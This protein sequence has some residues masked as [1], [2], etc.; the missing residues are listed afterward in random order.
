MNNRIEYIDTAKAILILC[1]LYGHYLLNARVQGVCDDTIVCMQRL[2][3]L[4]A[5][6][7]MQSF[8]I[9]TGFC[10]SFK[11]PFG[12]FLM[13][14]V[15]TILIPGITLTVL[16]RWLY[17]V[18]P[19]RPL[20]SSHS[21]LDWL[22]DGGPWFIMA[23]FEAKI[24]FY[25]I[26]RLKIGSQVAICSVLYLAALGLDRWTSTPNIL[27]FKHTLLMLP[28]LF[29]G[30]Y[31]KSNKVQIDRYLP[32]CAA[33][34]SLTLFAEFFIGFP[35]PILD[36]SIGVT[37]KTFPIH[38]LNVI[39]GTSAVIWVAKRINTNSFFAT[40]GKGTLLV[41]LTN[42]FIIKSI[43]LVL[44]PIYCLCGD[45]FQFTFFHIISY[46]LIVAVFF[47]LIKLVYNNRGMSWIVG[48]Y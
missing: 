35:M 18:M 9:I 1:L 10:S 36:N 16:N 21:A 2:V 12:A 40:F 28:W 34:G 4:Y 33:I 11:T 46:L 14:N 6:F 31:C 37:I 29:W 39:G 20:P 41:Y 22:I 44:S 26:S 42:E 47:W 23:L 8:F 15:K 7:F 5:A 13:K 19:G 17:G 43:I 32:S 3:K 30:Y 27:F 45:Y 38:I 48:K 24:L 25:F